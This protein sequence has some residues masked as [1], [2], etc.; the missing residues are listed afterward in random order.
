M[1]EE[2]KRIIYT[3]KVPE[4]AR[5]ESLRTNINVIIEKMLKRCR[6]PTDTMIKN[7]IAIELGHIN[8][9]HPDFIGGTKEY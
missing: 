6:D 5:F 8:T 7:I 9:R 1:Y 2:L 3:I 4:L